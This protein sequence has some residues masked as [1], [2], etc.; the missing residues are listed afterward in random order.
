[1]SFSFSFHEQLVNMRLEHE[2]K[3]QSKQKM[4]HDS[5]FDNEISNNKMIFSINI[6]KISM[7]KR[8]NRTVRTQI[9]K[10]ETKI[11]RFRDFRNQYRQKN[12]SIQKKN[13]RFSSTIVS[14]TKI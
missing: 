4:F 2:E 8:K 10:F 12:S 13:N 3:S 7:L 14:T 9:H 5:D 6:T 11:F 1:M